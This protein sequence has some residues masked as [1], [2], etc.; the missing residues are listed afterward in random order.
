MKNVIWWASVVGVTVAALALVTGRV[1]AG[2]F[3]DNN[4]N[5]RYVCDL[6]PVEA[7]TDKDAGVLMIL[8]DGKGGFKTGGTLAGPKAIDQS[9]PVSLCP[10]TSCSGCSFGSASSYHVDSNG[11]GTSSENY[12]LASGGGCTQTCFTTTSTF[13]LAKGGKTTKV[14]YEDILPDSNDLFG[15]R[16]AVGE[17]TQ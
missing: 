9:C 13:L 12:A 4:Y 2:S 16:R 14:V 11:V 15:G 5:G 7:S 8:P 10:G 1:Q 3:G 17:C 6:H